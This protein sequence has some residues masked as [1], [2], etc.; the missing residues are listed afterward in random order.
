VG[1][2]TVTVSIGLAIRGL[3]ALVA[4]IRRRSVIATHLPT[5][6]I[7]AALIPTYINGHTGGN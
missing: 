6:D 2:P 1:V 7:P 4:A 3:M 5:I